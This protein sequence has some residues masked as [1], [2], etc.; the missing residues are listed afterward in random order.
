[1]SRWDWFV[2]SETN[3]WDWM[4]LIGVLVV[5]PLWRVC[6]RAGLSGP[7]AL[8][9]LIPFGLI[10]VLFMLA[11]SEWP[12]LRRAARPPNEAA[13]EWAGRWAEDP[14]EGAR[15]S[16]AIQPEQKNIIEPPGERAG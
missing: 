8:L 2:I 7:L 4:L 3:P 10:V 12:A 5:W 1:M 14:A 13:E 16:E 6:S 11:F 9:A 15:P